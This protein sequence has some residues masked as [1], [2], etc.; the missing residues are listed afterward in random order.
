MIELSR[1][2]V[3]ITAIKEAVKHV[4]ISGEAV[5]NAIYMY[6][7][8]HKDMMGNLLYSIAVSNKLEPLTVGENLIEFVEKHGLG[9]EHIATPEELE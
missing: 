5:K 3:G 9:E 4:Q 8:G 2:E 1:I 7:L 6:K